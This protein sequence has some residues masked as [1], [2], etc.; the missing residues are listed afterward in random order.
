[1][2]LLGGISNHRISMKGRKASKNNFGFLMLTKSQKGHPQVSNN[3][4]TPAF[5]IS[6]DHS[7]IVTIGVTT[8][9]HGI[10]KGSGGPKCSIVF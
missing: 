4:R 2:L 10:V 9:V 1:M 6:S 8:E 7:M 5:C 3:H